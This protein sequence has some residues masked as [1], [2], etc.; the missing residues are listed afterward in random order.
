MQRTGRGCTDAGELVVAFFRGLVKRN[1]R[2]N[3]VQVCVGLRRVM[4]R[5]ELSYRC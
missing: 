1:L 3:Y 4:I 2:G 5:F